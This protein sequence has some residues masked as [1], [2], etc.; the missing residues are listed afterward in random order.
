MT[1]DQGNEAD[2]RFSAACKKMQYSCHKTISNKICKLLN[3]FSG[4]VSPVLSH[5]E[6][7]T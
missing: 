1:K 3:I 7:E 6:K 2:G 4:R 5:S